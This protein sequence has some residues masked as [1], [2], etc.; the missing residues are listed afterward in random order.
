MEQFKITKP[1]RLIELFGGIGSQA[2]ALKRLGVDFE[3]Y[4]LSEWEVAAVKS[5][6]AIHFPND[7]KDYSENK[8]KEQLVEILDKLGISADGKTPLAKDKI[9]RKS[10][11]WLRE[12]YN[13]FRATRN[14]GSVMERK[15][16][17]LGVRDT[18]NYCYLLCYSF[19]CQ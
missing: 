15:G 18:N 8:T 13:N 6:K 1:V 9:A 16:G 2:M 12:T 10:E 14:I 5:Y 4:R 3:H 19:P 7:N 17:D 11:G